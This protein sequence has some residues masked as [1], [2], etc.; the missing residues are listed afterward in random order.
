MHTDLFDGAVAGE[1]IAAVGEPGGKGLPGSRLEAASRVASY[2]ADRLPADARNG[3]SGLP[4]A[5]VAL[6]VD[7]AIGVAVRHRV[8][9]WAIAF[10]W[11]NKKKQD[12]KQKA[13]AL[14]GSLDNRL[15]VAETLVVI[16]VKING[17]KEADGGRGLA[18]ERINRTKPMTAKQVLV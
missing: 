10:E 2:P 3:R 17:R 14:I 5:V 13:N 11:P 9:V 4:A 18:R 15:R 7:A 16:E 6:L 1:E 12:K 8:G